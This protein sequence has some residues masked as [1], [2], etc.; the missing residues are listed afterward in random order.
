MRIH[1]HAFAL[2]CPG[3]LCVQAHGFPRPAADLKH[4]ADQ[5]LPGKLENFNSRKASVFRLEKGTA[6]NP[7]R[8]WET[9]EEFEFPL[10]TLTS[11]DE[12]SQNTKRREK[13]LGRQ[14]QVYPPKE[15]KT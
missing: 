14:K 13:D 10:L 11:V 12:P 5:D 4:E 2:H 9:G 8:K 15:Q 3:L 7:L 1:K 6:G